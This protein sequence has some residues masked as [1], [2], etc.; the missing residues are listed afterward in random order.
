MA[1]P[2]STGL[3]FYGVSVSG[4]KTGDTT[5][6][7]EFSPPSGVWLPLITPFRDEAI[8]AASLRRLIGH[9]ADKPL[10]G[11]IVR[12]TTGERLTLD[13]AEI[14]QLVMITSAA[15]RDFGLRAPLY[16]GVSGSDKRK[17]AQWL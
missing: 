6:A 4:L 9:F 16:L 2:V 3:L 14:E 15:Q 12:A 11:L 10:D 8:D 13:D 5:M 7:A 1:P 17:V